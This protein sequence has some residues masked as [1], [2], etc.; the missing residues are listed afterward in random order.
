MARCRST[1]PRYER[2]RLEESLE[3]STRQR[4]GRSTDYL[5]L[6]LYLDEREQEIAAPPLATAEEGIDA[7]PSRRKTTDCPYRR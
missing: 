1:C 6:R 3:L 4:R 5:W 7:V 2:A